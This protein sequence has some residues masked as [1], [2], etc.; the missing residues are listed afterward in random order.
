MAELNWPAIQRFLFEVPPLDWAPL[1]PAIILH[2]TAAG[3]A[4]VSSRSYKDAQELG[5]W[6]LDIGITELRCRGS[7]AMRNGVYQPVGNESTSSSTA[8]VGARPLGA[9]PDAAALGAGP[10]AA[11]ARPLGGKACGAT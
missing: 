2:H 7:A 4:G 10:T 3:G 9:T 5:A 6:A 11:I 1:D 8:A